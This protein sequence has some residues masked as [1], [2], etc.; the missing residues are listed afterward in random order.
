[1]ANQITS[2]ID[3]SHIDKLEKDTSFIYSF[4]IKPNPNLVFIYGTLKS[5][6]CN[7]HELFQKMP[8]DPKRR[9]TLSQTHQQSQYVGWAVTE[10][11]FPLVIATP[12]NIPFVL[13]K[14]GLGHVSYQSVNHV[15]I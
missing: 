15:N 8:Q 14:P 4:D 5:T 6:G 7:H 2:S 9:R 13:L 12:F 10:E 11:C 3:N 1:M